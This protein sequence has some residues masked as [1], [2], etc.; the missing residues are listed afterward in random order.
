MRGGR[1]NTVHQGLRLQ[2]RVSS[3]IA[4]LVPL[5]WASLGKVLLATV[6]VAV[7]L[8]N[9]LRQWLRCHGGLPVEWR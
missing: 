2:H 9:L 5:P 1:S 4:P 3:S 6:K 7:E 8:S